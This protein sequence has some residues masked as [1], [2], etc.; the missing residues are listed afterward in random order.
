VFAPN[1]FF[2]L[3]CNFQVKAILLQTNALAY[4]VPP[5]V[6]TQKR[7]PTLPPDGHVVERRLSTPG[8]QRHNFRRFPVVT[9]V[10]DQSR[11]R[12]LLLV[13]H[14]QLLPRSDS[15]RQLLAVQL[16]STLEQ[17]GGGS[18]PE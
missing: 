15:C 14:L 11:I 6:T 2:K 9:K 4:L 7:F 8:R 5:P 16:L 3:A 12:Q 1:T 10:A 18:F 13:H 17:T